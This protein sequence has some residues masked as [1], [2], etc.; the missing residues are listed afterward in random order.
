MLNIGVILGSTRPGRVGEQVAR[1]V[2]DRCEQRKDAT[3]HLLDIEDFNLPLLDEPLPPAMGKYSK[4][5]TLKWAAAI[6]PLDAFVF[7]TGEY[8]HG[9]PGALKNAIDFLY[10][11]W[12]NKACGFVSYGSA[13]GVRSVEHLRGVAAELQMADVRA[14]VMLSLATDF[15]KHTLFKP[16]PRH[17]KTLATLLDQLVLWGS[18]L[19]TVRKPKHT[20]QQQQPSAPS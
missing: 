8:N 13:M 16:D 2:H 12:N 9:I 19:R 18:A 17:E 11:E 1:W 6:D 3:Y 5:H 7:V 14:Q 4:P 15:E 20:Q 10:E